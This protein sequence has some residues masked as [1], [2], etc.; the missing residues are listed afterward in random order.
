[1]DY[2]GIGRNREL[3]A[4]ML[5]QL[6]GNA[7]RFMRQFVQAIMSVLVPK[8]KDQDPNPA[9]TMYVLMAIGD[10]AQVSVGFAFT[11]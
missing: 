10:L 3:S 7:Q 1:M 2:S 11:L 4:H 8:L 9:V 5:G 6:I